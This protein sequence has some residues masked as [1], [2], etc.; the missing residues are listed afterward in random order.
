MPALIKVASKLDEG[1]ATNRKKGLQAVC[2]IKKWRHG[3]W[4]REQATHVSGH[5]ENNRLTYDNTHVS[6]AHV[7]W[8]VDSP[9]ADGGTAGISGRWAGLAEGGDLGAAAAPCKQ[10]ERWG[11]QGAAF[12]PSLTGICSLCSGAHPSRQPEAAPV[13]PQTSF[14]FLCFLSSSVVSL[15]PQLRNSQATLVP[16][17]ALVCGDLA[18]RVLSIFHPLSQKDD[19]GS[20]SH[21]SIQGCDLRI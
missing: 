13:R 18:H 16:F 15:R 4:L 7:V 9:Q 5:S 11:G 14:W 3:P 1:T 17:S 12:Q 2:S 21:G 6:E 19:G 8:P 20:P 10:W